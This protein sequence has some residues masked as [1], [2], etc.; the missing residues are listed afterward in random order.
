MRD[1]HGRILGPEDPVTISA[2][3]D[4]EAGRFT[5]AHG[6][7]VSF[8]T[9]R[10]LIRITRGSFEHYDGRQVRILPEDLE[11]GHHGS[12]R[13]EDQM[14]EAVLG[15]KR[16]NVSEAAKLAAQAGVI[17]DHQADRLV[18]LWHEHTEPVRPDIHG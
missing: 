8:G 15:L 5:R 2:S 3:F 16:A 1:R 10:V 11:Y 17:T 9:K 13:N 7:V 12:P 18:Q 6:V 14:A 4:A